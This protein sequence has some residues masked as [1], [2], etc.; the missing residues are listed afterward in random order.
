MPKP[1]PQYTSNDLRPLWHEIIARTRTPDATPLSALQYLHNLMKQVVVAWPSL[2]NAILALAS[3]ADAG[4][5]WSLECSS[6]CD[7]PLKSVDRSLD[8]TLRLRTEISDMGYK[9]GLHL[10]SSKNTRTRLSF[11]LFLRPKTSFIEITANQQTHEMS[12]E[13]MS[14]AANEMMNRVRKEVLHRAFTSNMSFIEAAVQS[15]ERNFCSSIL[16]EYVELK[17]VKTVVENGKWA[18]TVKWSHER[19]K[20]EVAPSSIS[21]GRPVLLSGQ[22]YPPTSSSATASQQ[23]PRLVCMLSQNLSRS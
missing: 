2:D 5:T 23:N 3:T 22:R 11:Y 9:V 12:K 14:F 20:Q 21:A 16:N 8:F 4:S 19:F 17:G 15:L 7:N 1:G 10:A 18:G 13:T 6:T